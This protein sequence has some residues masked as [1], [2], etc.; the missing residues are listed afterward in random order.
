MPSS[1]P[2][3][4]EPTSDR[5]GEVDP[6]DRRQEERLRALVRAIPDL[7]FRMSGDGTYIDFNDGSAEPT[8]VP[9]EAFLGK[10]IRDLPLPPAFI[11]KSLFHLQRAIREGTLDV[12]EYELDDAQGR[13][14]HYEARFIRSGQDEAVCIVRNITERKQAEA[15]QAQLVQSEKMV[16]LGQMAAGIAHEISNPASYVM[17][18]L[19]TLRHYIE[20][21]Q[22]VMQLQRELMEAGKAVDPGPLSERLAGLR[23][24]W[25]RHRL[26]ELLQ[27]LPEL[28]QESLNG[29]QR[30]REIAQD[31]RV[32]THQDSGPM[33]LVDLNTELESA[34]RIVWSEIRHKCEVQREYGPLPSIA[35]YPSQLVQVF[36][37]LF[38]NA[39]QSIETQ[40]VIGIRTWQ[41]G[42]SVVVRISDTGKG[43]TPETL[44]RLSTPFFTTKPRGEGT[45]LGLSISYDIIARHKGRIEVQSEPGQGSTF[46]L[47]LPL[48]AR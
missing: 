22:P 41:E 11:E 18:N 47:H 32:F 39:A 13:R 44:A 26:E 2:G 19:G 48:S 31:L 3:S 28:I 37:N 38:V 29:T 35:C 20:Q 10:N 30:I 42:E 43:M 8:S 25:E 5:P 14:Q 16:L 46:T 15:R 21:F 9:P 1:P 36:T 7:I 6:A 33:Q 24:L 34:L 27:E 45:G 12:F 4:V 23:E 17:S 40:G